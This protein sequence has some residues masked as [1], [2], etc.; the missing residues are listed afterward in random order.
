M[1][2]RRPARAK[3]ARKELRLSRA[4]RL[5]V[6]GW[7]LA[8]LILFYLIVQKNAQWDR[9]QAQA[10]T[11]RQPSDTAVARREPPKAHKH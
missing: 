8:T 9:E 7:V 1:S 3:N 4:E 5:V 6:V 2:K 11:V 10:D